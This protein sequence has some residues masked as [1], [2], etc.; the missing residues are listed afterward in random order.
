MSVET[1]LMIISGAAEPKA[2]KEAPATSS[3]TFQR[4]HSVSRLTTRCSSATIATAVNEYSRMNSSSNKPR[5]DECRTPS[6]VVLPSKL[7]RQTFS[8]PT[9]HCGWQVS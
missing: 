5:K 7:S 6:A 4:T 8:K 2:I 9:Q 3:R 1:A